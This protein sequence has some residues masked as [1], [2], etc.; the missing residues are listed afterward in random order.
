MAE[1]TAAAD[2]RMLRD[3]MAITIITLVAGLILSLVHGITLEPIRL[4]EARAKEAACRAVF[5]DAD[6]FDSLYSETQDDLEAF[7]DSNGFPRQDIDEVMLARGAD[8][9]ALGY[10]ITV[11]TKEGYGGDIQFTMGVRSDGTLNGISILSISETAG[12]G[13][14]ADTAEFKA[15]FADKSVSLFRYTKNGARSADEIDALS[16]ATVTT[17][18]MTNGVN[19]GLTAFRYLRTHNIGGETNEG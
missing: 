3:V 8:G 17:N 13:M 9:E 10:V 6:R 12:L 11:T 14:R 1:K 7:L 18:A 2:S 5:A 19:A 16:G 15:Q 4:Q